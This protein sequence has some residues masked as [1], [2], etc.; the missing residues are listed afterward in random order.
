MA[1]RHLRNFALVT[2]VAFGACAD[3]PD[4]STGSADDIL[5][6]TERTAKGED[7][8]EPNVEMTRATGERQQPAAAKGFP[9]TWSG[10]IQNVADS[11][12][13]I[14]GLWIFDERGAYL[15]GYNDGSGRKTLPLDMVGLTKQFVP[16]G[17]GVRTVQVTGLTATPEQMT[18]N[19]SISFEKA[20]NGFL[21]QEFSA[22]TFEFTLLSDN[23]MRMRF[24]FTAST[25]LGDKI[26]IGG[27]NADLYEGRISRSR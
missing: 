8:I 27:S 9:G 12:D 7:E 24:A 21:E 6:A 22:M 20:S 5:N 13:R 15:Y 16:E 18:I 11:G 1:L 26:S 25:F 2:V 14:D 17:G 23:E 3:L 19:V 10:T 4:A